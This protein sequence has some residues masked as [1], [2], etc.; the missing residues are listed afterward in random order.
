MLRPRTRIWLSFEVILNEIDRRRGHGHRCWQ[1]ADSLIRR[2]LQ[3]VRCLFFVRIFLTDLSG[4]CPLSGLCP[5]S[6]S[7]VCL[8]GF[9]LSRF[10]PLS[11][12]CPDFRKKDCP[13]SFCPDFVCLDSVRCPDFV[14]NFRKN[15][16]RCLSV[17]PD[18]DETELSGF[19]VSL[20][21]DVCLV[22]WLI[23]VSYFRR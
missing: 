9:C 14:R 18:K 20:S 22:T 17:R 11:G 2:T 5:D 15:A 7:G 8:S 6:L 12:F 16:V 23:G 19:S 10:C 21:A 3:Y 4:V 13:M 1:T